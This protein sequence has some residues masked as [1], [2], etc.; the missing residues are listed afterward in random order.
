MDT[1]VY[2]LYG[3]NPMYHTELTGSVASLVKHLTT[4]TRVLLVCD[5]HNMRPDLPV[6]HLLFTAEELSKWTSGGTYNHE[7]KIHAMLKVMG[8]FPTS[9]I[10][11]VDTDTIWLDDPYKIFASISHTST[12]MHMDEGEVGTHGLWQGL[13][14]KGAVGAQE[15]MWNSGLV[16]LHPIHRAAVE[17]ALQTL[18][19]LYAVE[20]VFSVEQ[21]AYSRELAKVSTIHAADHVLK[22]YWGYE[23]RFVHQ[24]ISE[25]FRYRLF[26]PVANDRFAP[27]FGFPRTNKI[28]VILAKLEALVLRESSEYRFAVLAARSALRNPRFSR[29]WAQVSLDVA[30]NAKLSPRFLS[31]YGAVMQVITA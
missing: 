19:Q 28:D 7:S 14:T 24:Q 18:R 15:H 17:R 3:T 21:F 16:G 26:S 4:P 27:S 10:V 1:I 13:V 25:A 9:K 22:H 8:A 20:H 2:L 31:R 5:E 29:A 11:F 12:Y 23:R 6:E 30:K